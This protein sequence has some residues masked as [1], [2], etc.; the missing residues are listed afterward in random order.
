MDQAD[1][2]D[3]SGQIRSWLGAAALRANMLL[4]AAAFAGRAVVRRGRATHTVGAGARGT[5]RVVDAPG[6]PPNGFF[7][8]GREFPVLARHATALRVDEVERDFRSLAIKLSDGEQTDALDLVMNTGHV[9]GFWHGANFVRGAIGGALGEAGR[10]WYIRNN[11]PAFDNVLAGIRRAPSSF[12]RLS[13]YAAITFDLCALDGSRHLVRFRVVPWSELEDGLSEGEDLQRPWFERRL[14]GEDRAEGWLRAELGARVRAGAARY[15]LQSQVRQHTFEQQVYDIGRAWDEASHPWTE[16]G[17]LTLEQMLDPDETEALRFRIDHQPPCLGIP[18]ARS[19]WDYRSIGWMR[20]RIY[21]WLQAWRALLGRGRSVPRWDR[22]RA[23]ERHLW[24]RPHGFTVLLDVMSEPQALMAELVRVGDAIGELPEVPLERVSTLHF[25]RMQVI[26]APHPRLLVDWVYDGPLEA[27]L[28]EFLLHVGPWF[29]ALLRK[30]AQV[31][32][33]LRAALHAHCIRAQTL[34]SGDVRG[35]AEDVRQEHRLREV[36]SAFADAQLASGRW[37]AQTPPETLRAELRAHVLAR[38]EP[39]LPRGPRPRSSWRAFAGQWTDAARAVGAPWSGVLRQE[40]RR[41]LLPPS[42]RHGLLWRGTVE[43]LLA[44]HVVWTT[45]PSRWLL[46]R[47]RAMEAREP[48]PALPPRDEAA[49]VWREE[50][51]AQNPLT[52]VSAV[53]DHPHRRWLLARVLHGAD[54]ASRHIW[55]RGELAGI[56]TIHCARI[57]QIDEGRRMIFLSD[58]DGSW[59]RYLQDFLTVGAVAVVPIFANLVGCPKTSALFGTTRGF[60]S[61]FLDFTRHDQ[62]PVHLWYSAWPTL[63]LRNRLAN[64]RLREGL[65]AA[66][67]DEEQTRVWL[68]EVL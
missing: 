55:N 21:P 24:R 50:H 43:V 66:R 35:T 13:Y 45:L 53:Q 27:H 57:F 63:S 9:Q 52:M 6:L 19:P 41:W 67:M 23:A 22:G 40:I 37:T 34:H 64:A 61:R 5:L 2:Y 26:D 1:P 56:D 7:A 44:A 28:D 10:R 38:A 17:E 4:L 25:F 65:F 16:L 32:G 3:S 8:P 39:G 29:E 58:Y 49:V 62:A 54:D 48:E 15:R 47:A 12:C 11:P 60:A 33:P 18:E 20:P 68:Q 59:E 30:H 36:A 42:R 51:Q 14:P 46:A 31:Q